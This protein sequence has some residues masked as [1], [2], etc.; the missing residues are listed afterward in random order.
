MTNYVPNVPP[1]KIPGVREHWK[2]IEGTN[3]YVSDEGRFACTY[4]GERLVEPV[5][6]PKT[7]SYQIRIAG[8]FC[9][10]A[11]VVWE[12]FKGP[13]P[14]GY[15]VVNSRGYKTMWDIH[16]LK[17]ISIS[18]MTSN[19]AKSKARKVKDIETKKVYRNADEAGE[20]L[21]LTPNYVRNICEGRHPNACRKL[22]YI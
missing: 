8:R 15:C 19:A 4:N 1:I 20:D 21:F 13:V 17:L 14:E 22:V 3:Y 10:P 5:Y 12:A 9:I 7:N 16:S 2:H 11:R 6:K 18:E